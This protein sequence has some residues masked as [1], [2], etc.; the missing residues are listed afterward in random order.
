MVYI[1]FYFLLSLNTY[2]SSTNITVSLIIAFLPKEWNMEL[3]IR[4]ASLAAQLVKNLP[5]MWETWVWSLG[6]E[7]SPGEGKGCPLHYSG[8]ENY[9]DCIAHGEAKSWTR[10][11]HFHFQ[12]WKYRYIQRCSY[13]EGGHGNPL[14]YSCLEKPMD[15]GAW[16]GLKS[17]GSQ[18]VRHN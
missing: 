17:M 16:Q 1:N 11:S 7:D 8:L 12:I 15:R 5:A 13:K 2:L 14:Q 3:Q 4:K 18:R 9:T 6:W 10:L